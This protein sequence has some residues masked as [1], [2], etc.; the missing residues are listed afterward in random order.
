MH[1]QTHSEGRY[2]RSVPGTHTNNNIHSY[3]KGLLHITASILAIE[4]LSQPGF[5]Q[6][7]VCGG[8]GDRALYMYTGCILDIVSKPP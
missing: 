7:C 1:R 3:L 2:V 4:D 5:L 8:E 6:V